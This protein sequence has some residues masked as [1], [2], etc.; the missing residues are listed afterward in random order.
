MRAGI[1]RITDLACVRFMS[2]DLFVKNK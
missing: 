2:N 1:A